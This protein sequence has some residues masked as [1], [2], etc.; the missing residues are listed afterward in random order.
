MGSPEAQKAIENDRVKIKQIENKTITMVYAAMLFGF[1]CQS[2]ENW[3]PIRS[4]LPDQKLTC[5]IEILKSWLLYR[6]NVGALRAAEL[7]NVI[8]IAKVC[9]DTEQR[10]ARNHEKAKE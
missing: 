4:L 9:Y 8:R 7:K 5:L 1:L 10:I 6:S 3:R 2:E